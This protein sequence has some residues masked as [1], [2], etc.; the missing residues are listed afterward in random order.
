MDKRMLSKI[1]AGLKAC[2]YG[3]CE[4]CPYYVPG[5]DYDCGEVISAEAY[6]VI[7]ELEEKNKELEEKSLRSAFPCQAGDDIYCVIC[8]DNNY[9]IIENQVLEIFSHHKN[10]I[11]IGTGYDR[12]WLY[13]F[14]CFSTPEEAQAEA[15]RRNK[16]IQ[17]E[18]K[19]K[20]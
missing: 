19:K 8:V 5:V 2:S 7:K 13:G 20:K 1:K 12:R 4:K 3:E 17:K 16:E 6:E 9:Q 10:S 15:D 18:A 11:I 14:D